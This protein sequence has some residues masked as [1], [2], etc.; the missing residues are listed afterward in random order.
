[1]KKGLCFLMAILLLLVLFII[2]AG[3]S[4]VEKG[5]EEVLEEQLRST[6]HYYNEN[7]FTVIDAYGMQG[8]VT[9]IVTSDDPSTSENEEVIEEYSSHI[10]VVF[11]ELEQK[12]DKLFIFKKKDFYYYD[13]DKEEFLT[14]SNVLGNDSIREFFDMYVDDIEKKITAFS[15]LLFLF[16]LSF[17]ITVPLAI[18]IFHNR[19]RSKY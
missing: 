19:G 10:G 18:M 9:K 4:E 5:F 1:M 14:A 2:P 8:N 15:K 11:L 13:F 17:I 7:S 12:R 16:F 6:V 3:A